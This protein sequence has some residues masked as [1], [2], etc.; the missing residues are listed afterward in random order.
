MRESARLVCLFATL[1]IACEGPGECKL[2][3]ETPTLTAFET[4]GKVQVA[5]RL[6]GRNFKNNLSDVDW[7][8]EGTNLTVVVDHECRARSRTRQGLSEEFPESIGIRSHRWVLGK[9]ISLADLASEAQNDRCVI[10]ISRPIALRTF[11]TDPDLSRQGHLQTVKALTAAPLFFGSHGIKSDVILA[12][13]DTGIDLDHEDLKENIWTNPGEIKGNFKD[14]DNNG[15][16]DDING[17]NFASKKGDANFEG[18]EYHG[19]HVAGLAAARLDNGVGGSG[20][21]GKKVRLMSLNVFGRNGGAETED[22][23]NAIRYAADN[24][25]NVINMSLGGRGATASTEQAIKY[26]IG[27]G[28]VLV[29]AAGNENR[30]LDETY[31]VTPAS[32]GSKF[33]GVITVGSIDVSNE[34]RSTFSNYSPVNVEIGAPGSIDSSNDEGLYSTMLSDQYGRIQG[35]SM[36]SPVA[37]GAAALAYGLL[38]T[39][40]VDVTP[41]IVEDLLIETGREVSALAGIFKGRV[42]DAEALYR[43][44]DSRYPA[45]ATPTPTP[46]PTPVTS[47]EPTPEPTSP[48]ESPQPSPVPTPCPTTA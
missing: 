14:D 16:V 45:G 25:A 35:T 46:H 41:L 43:T 4:H 13:I 10:G 47:P 20:V 2:D 27:K 23:D 38:K 31:F 9:D 22:L 29:V 28:V 17:Y 40:G 18:Q 3:A 30:K 11:A 36:A 32:Y 1:L 7:L 24:G 15:Y 6:E 21:I 5:E 19:T 39:R 26:A 48:P 12:V 34:I 44:I 37:A 8:K 33:R 42:V